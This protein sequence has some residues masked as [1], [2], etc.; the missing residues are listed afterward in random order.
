MKVFLVLS[1][2][3]AVACA[4]DVFFLHGD[5]HDEVVFKYESDVR[6]AVIDPHVTASQFKLRGDLHIR[7]DKA[8]NGT[9]YWLKNVE[10]YA[11]NGEVEFYHHDVDGWVPLPKESEAYL[12]PFYVGYSESGLVH[13]I[14]FQKDEPEWT[15]NLKKAIASMVQLDY[16]RVVKEAKK[17]PYAFHVTEHT[18][19]GVC[20]VSYSVVPHEK[21]YVIT[22][23]FDPKHCDGEYKDVYT[24]VVAHQCH[25]DH[26][27]SYRT[28]NKKVF[29]V[30]KEGVLEEIHSS[31]QI[32]VYPLKVQENLQVVYVN[33]TFEFVKYVKPEETIDVSSFVVYYPVYFRMPHVDELMNVP[34]YTFGRKVVDVESYVTKVVEMFHEAVEYVQTINFENTAPHTKEGLV[35]SRIVKFMKYFDVEHFDKVY[36]I[37]VKNTQPK[38]VVALEMFYKILPNVGTRPSALFVKNLVVA[39]KTKDYIAA[40]MLYTLGINMHVHTEKVLTELEELIHLEGKVKPEVHHAAVLTYA[41]LIYETYKDHEESPVL[42][43]YIKEYYTHLTTATKY[44]EKLVWL[45][46]LA[47]IRIGSVY[48]LFVPIVHGEEVFPYDRHL[49][50]H[51]IWNIIHP[52]QDKHVEAFEIF[53]PVLVDKSLHIELRVAAL[54]GLMATSST[55]QLYYIFQYM[56]TVH[57]P[58]LYNFFYTAVKNLAHSEIYCDIRTNITSFA[59]QVEQYFQNAPVD[60]GTSA[61]IRDY[62]DEDYGVGFSVYGNSIANEKTNEINQV[63]MR[64]DSHV[65]NYYYNN[66]AVHVKF[67][68]IE[69][70]VETFFS[71]LV[72]FSPETFKGHLFKKTGEPVHVEIIVTHHDQVVFVKYFTEEDIKGIFTADFFKMITML[73]YFVT[74]I[75]YTVQKEVIVPTDAGFTAQFYKYSPVVYQFKSEVPVYKPEDTQVTIKTSKYFRIWNHAT[76]GV[77]MYNPLGAYTQGVRRVYAFDANVPLNY[78]LTVNYKTQSF[79]VVMEKQATEIYNVFGVKTHVKSQVYSV[80]DKNSDVLAHTCKDCKQYVTVTKG[81]HFKHNT[82]L[83]DAHTRFNGAQYYFGMYDCEYTPQDMKSHGLAI[84]KMTFDFVKEFG[85]VPFK[86]FAVHAWQYFLKSAYLHPQGTCGLIAYVR[87]CTEHPVDT[88]EFTV[89]IEREED[90][91]HPHIPNE[92]EVVPHD[93]VHVKLNFSTKKDSEVVNE[94]FG[95]VHFHHEFGHLFNELEVHFSGKPHEEHYYTNWCFDRKKTYKNEKIEGAYKFYYGVSAERECVKDEFVASVDYT[96]E[97]SQEQLEEHVHHDDAHTYTDCQPHYPWSHNNET[98]YN[99]MY[100]HTTLRHYKY[101]INYVNVPSE[102]EYYFD[103]IWHFLV[104]SYNPSY[105]FEAERHVAEDSIAVDLLYPIAYHEPVAHVVVSHHDHSYVF[106]DF[107]VSDFWWF[108]QPESLH[109]PSYFRWVKFLNEYQVCAIYPHE[110]EHYL[111]HHHLAKFPTKEWQLYAASAPTNYTWGVYVH[112]VEN[113]H[114]HDQVAVKFVV[115]GHW[116]IVTPNVDV[117]HTYGPAKFQFTTDD[118]MLQYMATPYE[119]NELFGLEMFYVN[120]SIFFTIPQYGMI[121]TYDGHIVRVI[122]TDVDHYKYHGVCYEESH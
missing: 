80:P 117:E 57:C 31:S 93:H 113:E 19:Y 118:K 81:D 104:T 88:F 96:A 29:H 69:Y 8:G 22:K 106:D 116:V 32:F 50:V 48:K 17:H 111:P 6:T 92:H 38:D 9:I 46:G 20:D 99:C 35:I 94:W 83:F 23:Y 102:F 70:P 28:P 5:G 77:R 7:N 42:E 120:D 3:L 103:N 72:T 30:T 122:T 12:T 45:Q 1:A 112:K 40:A 67:E 86:K 33:Q 56:Q 49:R 89:K 59:E 114:D 107:P 18:I 25:E 34:D 24:N 55:Q 85:H 39:N 121:W 64:F 36:A 76:Y 13:D 51:A 2:L 27:D 16:A 11:Y 78:Q 47:N 108:S 52:L 21:E 75:Q 62:I 44:E 4:Y 115:N 82:E 71:D 97:Y 66:L 109:I 91:H 65:S 87:P 101:F 53:W 63:F 79:K 90:K 26:D 14:M 119:D 73:K 68:G 84:P 10:I 95:K 61:W 74:G 58:H 100:A 41:T 37:L 15:Y 105:V 43:K 110:P 54:K 60:V 98:T